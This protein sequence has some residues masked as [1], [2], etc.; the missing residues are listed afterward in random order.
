MLLPSKKPNMSLGILNDSI[1]EPQINHVE[2]LEGLAITART[3]SSTPKVELDLLI[4][5]K[6]PSPDRKNKKLPRSYSDSDLKS[7]G[8]LNTQAFFRPLQEAPVQEKPYFSITDSFESPE[9]ERPS[10]ECPGPESPEPEP[11]E[12]EEI[13]TT[14]CFI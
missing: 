9:I 8:E 6:T 1:V 5:A 2:Y 11:L 12:V 14:V 7:L 10:P 4:R 13:N 3:P